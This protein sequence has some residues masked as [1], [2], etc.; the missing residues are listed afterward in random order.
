MALFRVLCL[1]LIPAVWTA[2]VTPIEKVIT[3]IED[4]K[5]EVEEDGKAEAEAYDKFA[6]FCK[7]T[8]MDKSKSVNKGHETIESESASIAEKTA[9]RNED[10]SE[11]QERKTKQE[12]MKQELTET[13]NRFAKETA[14]YEVAA[15][16]LSKAISDLKNAIKALEDSKPASLLSIRATLVK[17]FQIAQAQ[18][19]LKTPKHKAVAALFQQSSGVDPADPEYG[20]HSDD[21]IEV[22]QNLLKEY[23]AAKKDLD[24][25]WAKTEKAF[26]EKIAA[27]EKEIAA[28]KA[29]MEALEKRIAKLAEEI[30]KHREDLVLAKNQMEDDELYIKDLTKRCEDRSHDYDQRSFM[31]A[32]ELKALTEALE[33]LKGEVE[34]RANEVN[35]RAM[36]VQKAKNAAKPA[37]KVATVVAVKTQ[38]E[39]KKAISFLQGSSVSADARQAQKESALDVLRQ[40]GRRLNSMTLLSLVSRI[41]GDPFSKVKVLIQRLIE[42]L[43]TEAKNEATKKGFCDTEIG[44][45]EKDRDYRY[46]EANDLSA[47]L[48]TLEAKR[49]FLK[50]EIKDLKK[51]I[52][53]EKKALEE[54][55]KDR[56]E[57]KEVNQETLKTAKE[58]LEGVTEAL[59][60][61]RSFYKQAAKAAFVQASP[62]DEDTEG[63]GFEGNYK[64][65]QSGMKAVFAL[66]ETIASDFERTLAVTAEEEH[67]AHRDFVEFDQTTRASIA[68]KE[69]KQKLDEEDLITTETSIETKMADFQ[70]SVDLLDKALQVIEELKPTC[71][72]TG[73]SYAERV[74]K[75]EEEIAALKKALVIL[76]PP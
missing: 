74:Q 71:I 69:T 70:T 2:D 62:V 5:T 43:L 32:D 63:P 61:L 36:L 39:S 23:R 27:L 75:R 35:V 68:G 1:S 12:Q 49:D 37:L 56:K 46:E 52:K 7:D 73:M 45:A 30:A 22:C 66:L 34:E 72:D 24:D 26:T 51:D 13:K 44:K 48:A 40:E 33:V 47:E 8:T 21:I 9:S 59:K 29:A 55:T 31:R 65:K 3:L 58:G 6:C 50:E 17:T 18:G 67:H 11:L 64:G 19:L 54:T 15:A 76:A 42:R 10:I 53:Q 28:N 16:D 4:I 41:D 57:E 25:E 60:I 14:E 20:Y 38:K